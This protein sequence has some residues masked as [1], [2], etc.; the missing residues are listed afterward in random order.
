MAAAALLLAGC[1]GGG[2][3]AGTGAG[4]EGKAKGATSG[5][6][7][8]PSAPAKVT[9]GP[10]LDF[11]L[12]PGNGKTVGVGHP[13][14]LEFRKPVKNKAVVE[15]ALTVTTDNNTEGSWGWVKTPTGYDRL[16]WRP[17]DYWKPGTKVRVQ[18]D[19]TVVDPGDGHF[20][21]TLDRAFTIGRDQRMLADLDKHTLTVTQDGRKVKTFPMTG[22][23]PVKDRASRPGIFVSRPGRRRSG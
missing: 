21:R 10:E 16:D 7:P 19:L 5:A 13:V 6:S 3:D 14:S 9:T 2:G 20:T 11:D 12:T 17:K 22:G 4:D 15:K 18:G 23:E 1:R 8:Q